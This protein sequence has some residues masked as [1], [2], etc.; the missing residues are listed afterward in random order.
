MH[1]IN[2]MLVLMIALLLILTSS[3]MYLVMMRYFR[4]IDIIHKCSFQF[5]HI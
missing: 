1:Y 5:D 4:F 2:K 3:Y